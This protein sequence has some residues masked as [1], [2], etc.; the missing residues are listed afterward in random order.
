MV[1]CY[2]D[3]QAGAKLMLDKRTES[4]LSGINTLCAEGTY[5]ILETEEILAVLPRKFKIDADG[6]KQMVKYLK[7]RDYIDVKYSDEQQ[8]C[9]CTLPKGRLYFES[10]GKE[11][12]EGGKRSKRLFWAAFLGG[13]GGSVIGG[14]IGALIAAKFLIG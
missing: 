6:L 14:V 7:D 10:V 5:K 4:V 8:Y 9:L 3:F 13:I 2:T 12:R 1:Q 11:K